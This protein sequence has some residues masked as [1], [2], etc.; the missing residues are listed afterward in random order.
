MSRSYDES[1]SVLSSLL[2]RYPGGALSLGCTGGTWL[3]ILSVDVPYIDP[4]NIEPDSRLI[5]LQARS[6]EAEKAL[7]SLASK[8]TEAGL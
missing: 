1:L 2:E 3:A 4:D 8:L 6:C 5:E 7:D